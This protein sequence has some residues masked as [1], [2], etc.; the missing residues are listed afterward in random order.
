MNKIYNTRHKNATTS[1]TPLSN[2]LQI[3]K[4]TH[5]T[6][7][8]IRIISLR[9]QS[10]KVHLDHILRG[11]GAQ[12]VDVDGLALLQTDYQGLAVAGKQAAGVVVVE[13]GVEARACVARQD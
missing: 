12:A 1:H 2:S 9:H 4:Q 11:H 3:L 10:H 6:R 5:R 8:R 13:E 7:K